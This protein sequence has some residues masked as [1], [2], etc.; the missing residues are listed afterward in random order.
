MK[1][2]IIIS[3]ILFAFFYKSNAQDY[4]TAVGIRGGTSQGI[5]VKH[6]LSYETAIE[7]IV[8]TRWRGLMLIGL[9]EFEKQAFNV[10]GLKWFYGGGAHAGFF[11]DSNY[12]LPWAD[13]EN[14][15]NYAVLGVDGIIGLEYTFIDVPINISV[16]YKPQ[17]NFF[18]YTGLW[19]DAGAISIR[20]VFR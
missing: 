7:G 12:D 13:N 4:N 16:D 10:Y 15:G 5:S 2:I 19:G 3:L 9:Y 11:N 6:F 8:S 1:K 17:M 18:G 20:Y 14:Y